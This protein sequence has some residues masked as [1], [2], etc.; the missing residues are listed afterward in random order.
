MIAGAVATK[1][2]AQTQ[3][4]KGKMEKEAKVREI[5]RGKKKG[6]NNGK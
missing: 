5:R 3:K 6:H 2:T 4:V 1:E